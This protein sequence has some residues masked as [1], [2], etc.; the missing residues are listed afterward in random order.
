MENNTEFS[1]G[2]QSVCSVITFLIMSSIVL[3]QHSTI[4]EIY[5]EQIF[6]HYC[7]FYDFVSFKFPLKGKV[8]TTE[9]HNVNTISLGMVRTTNLVL[10]PRQP[11]QFFHNTIVE[12]CAY[13]MKYCIYFSSTVPFSSAL[14]SHILFHLV[15][16]HM[17]TTLCNFL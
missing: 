12:F 10:N 4:P 2:S 11:K 3:W 1:I 9:K 13:K 6:I 17:Y 14:Y 16:V 5:K 15:L 8:K 7:Q